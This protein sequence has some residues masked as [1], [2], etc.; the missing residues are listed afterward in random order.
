M[1]LNTADYWFGLYKLTPTKT[2]TTKW[3][4]ENPSKYRKWAKGHPNKNTRCIRYTKGGFRD[5]KC[6]HPYYYTCKKDAGKLLVSVT[7]LH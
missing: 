3:Y 5:M 6:S 1:F 4:D 2:G 7:T